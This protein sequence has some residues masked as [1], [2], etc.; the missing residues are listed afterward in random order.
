[1]KRFWL[2]FF[3]WW[4]GSTLGTG[5]RTWRTGEL[6]GADEYGNRYYRDRRG[7]DRRWVVYADLVEASVVGPG[8]HGWLH[9]TTDVAPP[10]SGYRPRRWE[11]PHRPNL[12]GTPG[13]YRP[14]GSILTPQHRPKVTGDYEPWV[15]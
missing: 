15:P 14:P 1:M 5:F 12:T 8:W 7:G 2:R 11:R 6:V 9:H 10:Q 4:H 3:T 13:A